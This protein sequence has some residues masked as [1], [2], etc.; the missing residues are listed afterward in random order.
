MEKAT[1]KANVSMLIAALLVVAGGVGVFGASAQDNEAQTDTTSETTSAF[2]Q[3]LSE[4]EQATFQIIH[5]DVMTG[6][7][8]HKEAMAQ[9]EAE[10]FEPPQGPEKH[11]G[12][13]MKNLTK[14]EKEFTKSIHEQVMAG[15]LT[16]EEAMTQLKAT[17]I[18][19]PLK[20]GMSGHKG[21]LMQDLTE[22]QQAIAKETHQA[23]MSGELNPK[24]GMEQLEAAGIEVP[25]EMKTF[26]EG[27]TEEQLNLMQ[28]LRQQKEAGEIT[29][30]EVHER[31]SEA[32]IDMPK[33]PKGHH[34]GG[35]MS[36]LTEEERSEMMKLK[37]SGNMEAFKEYM[38]TLRSEHHAEANEETEGKTL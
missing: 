26:V 20:P 22:E 5:E 36:N 37:E 29:H 11:M 1:K 21:Q 33:G 30:Q 8:S 12:Y 38:N 27:L 23:I 28:E 16:H 3:E 32:G 24:E 15:E 19:T 10:G 9:L 18:E 2:T 25:E 13:M 6:N 14:E 17:G 35:F 4:K 7:L 31:L 34:K